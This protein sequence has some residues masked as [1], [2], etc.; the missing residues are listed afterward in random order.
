MTI[1]N[2][3]RLDGLLYSHA[4]LEIFCDDNKQQSKRYLPNVAALRCSKSMTVQFI[5]IG[6]SEQEN[7]KVLIRPKFNRTKIAILG[8]IQLEDNKK[9]NYK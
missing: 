6:V 3:V 1:S 2:I 7:N 4:C 8:D 9:V 5:F